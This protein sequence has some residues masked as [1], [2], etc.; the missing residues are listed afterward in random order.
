MIAASI[1]I[2]AMAA[3]FVCA[4]LLRLGEGK[5]CGSDHCGSCSNDC[6]FDTE[7]RLP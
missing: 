2:F 3:L 7:G 6:E 4:G 5:G 1:G